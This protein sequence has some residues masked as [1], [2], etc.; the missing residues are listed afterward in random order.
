MNLKRGDIILVDFDPARPS[1]ANKIRPS[2]LI[3]NNQANTYGTNVMVVPL[4]SN[5]TSIYPFQ[6][7]LAAEQTGLKEDS[8]A[9]VELSRSVS[10]SRL[11]KRIASLNESL[12]EQLNE[13]LKL[14]LDL[15]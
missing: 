13:R 1:E 9:Q 15:Y 12:L 8:K 3:T 10:K 14:H 6:L 11:G 5:I 4:T 7:F 2:I